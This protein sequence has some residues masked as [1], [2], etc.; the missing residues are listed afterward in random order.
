[1]DCDGSFL[2]EFV[3]EPEE[4]VYPMVPPGKSL[5][6]TM[7]L[8]KPKKVSKRKPKVLARS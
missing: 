5:S 3:V 1:M 7:E 6:E 4:N 8:P 2:I